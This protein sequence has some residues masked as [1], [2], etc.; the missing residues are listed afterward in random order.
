LKWKKRFFVSGVEGILEK[1][2][3]KKALLTKGQ[4]EEISK[5]LRNKTPFDFGYETAFWTTNILAHLIEEQYSVKYKSKTPLYVLFRESKFTYHLPGKK[6]QKHDQNAIDTWIKENKSKIE[7]YLK[8]ENTVVL[9]ADEMILSS[10]TTT[11]KVWLPVGEYEEIKISATRK[12][13][14]FYGFLN[15]S[16]GQENAYIAERQNSIITCEMLEKICKEYR[17]KKVVIIW[18]NAPW[19]RGEEVKKWLS[20][21]K[22]SIHLIAFPPYSPELNPQEHVWKAARAAASHNTFIKNLEKTASR[23]AEYLNNNLFQYSFLS[24]IRA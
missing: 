1:K 15:L 17:G 2:K 23:F 14:S 21:T 18:D 9:V 19:H 4:R 7:E 8:E 3:K 13:K 6:Y 10:Q 16:S 20:K 11:Q 5:I 22:Y 12:N 24:I